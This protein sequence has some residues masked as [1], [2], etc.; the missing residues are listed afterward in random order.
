MLL[1]KYMNI[2]FGVYFARYFL[3]SSGKKQQ[4]V[5]LQRHAL[6]AVTT[7]DIG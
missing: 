2:Y 5:A 6:P 1:K 7:F 3:R 4:A